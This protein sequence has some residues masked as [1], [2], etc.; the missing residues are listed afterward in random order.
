MEDK[1]KGEEKE[2][3]FKSLVFANDPKMYNRLF[4]EEAEMAR[5]EEDAE[6]IVPQNEKELQDLVAE[7]EDFERQMKMA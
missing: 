3:D 2:E 4:S 5:V 7:I 1:S 6:W